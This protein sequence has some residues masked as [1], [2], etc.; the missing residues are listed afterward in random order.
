MWKVL[1][2]FPLLAAGLGAPAELIDNEFYQKDVRGGRIAGL[3]INRNNFAILFKNIRCTGGTEAA[4]NQFPYQVAFFIYTSDGQSICGG[5]VLSANFVLSAAHCFL[6]F[7]SADLLAGLHNII[8]DNPAY[9]LEVFPSDII[10][11]A[12]YNRVSHLNDIALARTNRRPI[13]FSAAIQPL[14]LASR[15][16]ASIE[17]TGVTGRIAGW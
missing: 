14:P 9:E 6:S 1:W 17:L 5:S 4:R 10:S 2:V 11:H 13:T 3:Q 16:M 8:S 7:E 15:A 12:Q